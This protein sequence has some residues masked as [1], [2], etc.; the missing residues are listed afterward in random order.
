MLLKKRQALTIVILAGLLLAMV[1]GIVFVIFPRIQSILGGGLNAGY[2]GS[3]LFGLNGTI[4]ISSTSGGTLTITVLNN[5]Y[6]AFSKIEITSITPG[7][8]GPS[9]NV[10]FSHEGVPVSP[11]NP[12]PVG[13]SATASYVFGSGANVGTNYKVTIAAIPTGGPDISESETIQAQS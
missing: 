11:S 7:L 2:N 13:D 12:L 9:L 6:A 10:N 3:D 8:Q 1:A 5:A 4:T